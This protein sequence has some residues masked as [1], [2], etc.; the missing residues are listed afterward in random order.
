MQIRTSQVTQL[1]RAKKIESF[2]RLLAELR[3]SAP[4]ATSHLDD[5]SLLT[6]IEQATAK[7][8]KYGVQSSEATTAFVKIAVFVGPSFDK[9]A[10]VKQFLEAPELDPDYKVTLLAELVSEKLKG[11]S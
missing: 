1:D 4:Q 6:I 10:A 7:A 5:E 9:D 3:H 2:R 8:R 11:L